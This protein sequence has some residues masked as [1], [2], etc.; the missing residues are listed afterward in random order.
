[1]PLS[2]VVATPNGYCILYLDNY[3]PADENEYAKVKDSLKEA[4]LEE[5]QDS[6]FGDF[7][8]QLRVKADFV[9]NL[10]NLRKQVQ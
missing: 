2:G 1:L 10:A 8:T 4:L 9:D 3:V 5:K 7:V 6:V